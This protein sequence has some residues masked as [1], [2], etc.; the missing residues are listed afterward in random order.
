MSLNILFKQIRDRV[1]AT[2]QYAY[3]IFCI[4]T[5]NELY[6]FLKKKSLILVDDTTSL[7]KYNNFAMMGKSI[8]RICMNPIPVMTCDEIQYIISEYFENNII[9]FNSKIQSLITHETF[10]TEFDLINFSNDVHKFNEQFIIYLSKFIQEN[11]MSRVEIE[12][13]KY[14]D[15][16]NLTIYDCIHSINQLINL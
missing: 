2:Q 3:G 14:S 4:N 10:P 13:H 11:D 1:Y 9:I 12:Y 6:I 8:S 16:T 15:Y 7:D 5:L